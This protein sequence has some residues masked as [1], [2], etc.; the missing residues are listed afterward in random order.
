MLC[1]MRDQIWLT[2]ARQ[3]RPNGFSRDISA[4][5][6]I[7]LYDSAWV[8]FRDSDVPQ[9]VQKDRTNPAVFLVG[10]YRYDIDGRPYSG[11]EAMPD[12]VEMLS[13]SSARD[14]GLPTSYGSAGR[15]YPY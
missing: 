8:L 9:Q 2:N 7:R 14:R 10:N 3:A 1:A 13:M 11:G 5:M 15:G 6:S 4:R 12:I